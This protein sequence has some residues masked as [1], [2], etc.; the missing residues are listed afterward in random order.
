MDLNKKTILVQIP[1]YKDPRLVST[2]FSLINQAEFPDRVHF[3]ICYQNDNM[4]D[5]KKLSLLKNCK[6]ITVSEADSRGTCYARYLCQSLLD[7]EDFVF[8]IDSHM[9]AIKNWDT[10]IIDQWYSLNNEKA[11]ISMYPPADDILKDKSLNDDVYK[12]SADMSFVIVAKQFQN[13]RYYIDFTYNDRVSSM[14]RTVFI[15]AGYFFGPSQADM[16]VIYDVRGAFKG[17]ELPMSIRLW[18]YGYDVYSPDEMYLYHYYVSK[19]DNNLRLFPKNMS[20]DAENEM[21]E[22]LIG[23]KSGELPDNYIGNVR[24]IKEY[25]KFSGISF[26]N[27]RLQAPST[28]G[29]FVPETYKSLSKLDLSLLFNDLYKNIHNY[30]CYE[31]LA[32]SLWVKNPNQA[33]LCYEQAIF[34]CPDD[35]PNYAKWYLKQKFK[36]FMNIT[37]L[38]LSLTSFIVVCQRDKGNLERCLDSIKNVCAPGSYEIIVVSNYNDIEN[39]KC[40]EG[41]DDI[42]NVH[43]YDDYG[44]MNGAKIGIFNACRSNDIFL[45]NPEII[46]SD[47]ALF[48]LKMMLYKYDNI[49]SVVPCIDKINQEN[50]LL[51]NTMLVKHDI[52]DT[53]NSLNQFNE[54]YSYKMI[55]LC[56]IIQKKDFKVVFCKDV[57]LN[58]VKKE[59]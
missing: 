30:K 22:L 8:H 59:M 49:G 57:L 42:K 1:S 17:D 18:T 25:E 52:Y 23:L 34:L 56:K 53:I 36:K 15:A 29:Y 12:K 20:Y 9:T 39:N 41:K 28:T 11:I 55:D 58:S 44:F 16:D 35:E 2:V 5:Y 13:G 33:Y 43:V 7:D 19:K 51:H 21:L 47:N 14:Q 37:G 38:S 31:K 24:T 10:L 4:E 3:A 27:K 32:D 50:V 40:L 48:L 46:L 54:V 45:L 6:I 26:K